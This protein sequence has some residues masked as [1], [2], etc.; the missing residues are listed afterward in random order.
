MHIDDDLKRELIQLKTFTMSAYHFKM[1]GYLRCPGRWIC[2]LGK[3]LEYCYSDVGDGAIC[4]IAFMNLS[5][6]A[7]SNKE[8]P[9][10]LKFF[11]LLR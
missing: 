1:K 9:P 2:L 4:A 3:S 10:R 7:L 5:M 11:V 6:P 8:V